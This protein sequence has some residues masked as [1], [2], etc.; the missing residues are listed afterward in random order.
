MKALPIL[1][2]LAACGL[3]VPFLARAE[4]AA[5]PEP[6]SIA[7]PAKTFQIDAVHSA[8]L[9][10]IKHQG[11][12]WN[13]GRFTEFSGEVVFDE[14]DPAKSSVKIEV[15]ADSVDTSNAKRNQHVM[16]PDFFD[17]KQF[18][19]LSF[20]STSVAKKGGTW[21]VEGNLEFHGTNK[22]ITVE[23]EKTGEGPGRGGATVAGFHAEFEIK[24][25]DYG[26]DFMIGPLSDEVGIIISLEA[27][28][29]E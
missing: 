28:S 1:A 27:G 8:I 18:P 17:V 21:T 22:K 9:F 10:K 14:A 16:S 13:Y 12:A 4:A 5:A 2:A 24:R 15:K 6:A 23:F 3:A 29:R 7:A 19:T 25:S 26:I 20:E 11:V